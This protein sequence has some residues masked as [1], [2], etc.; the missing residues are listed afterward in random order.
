M[1][2][3]N[4]SFKAKR[5]NA[6]QAVKIK[7]RCKFLG[8][9]YEKLN[10][11][12]RKSAIRKVTGSLQW[13]QYLEQLNEKHTGDHGARP[14]AEY[15]KLVRSMQASLKAEFKKLHA[16]VYEAKKQS[17]LAKKQALKAEADQKH[18]Q[19]TDERKRAA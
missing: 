3:A 17:R 8:I 18:H 16:S 5:R 4:A 10:T 12:D 9:D 1:K 15:S 7:A 2:K 14:S 13:P 11:A 6:G 19:R